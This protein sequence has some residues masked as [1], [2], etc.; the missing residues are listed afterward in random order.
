MTQIP[1]ARR[2]PVA[3]E[4]CNLAKAIDVVGDRWTLLILRAAMYG[5]RRFD[6]FQAELGAPRTVLSG[7]LKTLVAEGLLTK[8]AY[9]S[10]GRRAR[11][12]YV[13][14][15]MGVSLRPILIG[16]TQWGDAW[17]AAGDPPPISFTKAPGK[18]P[19]RAAFVDTEGREVR[20]DQIRPI[21]K[22]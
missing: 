17:L 6:D 12:E 22:G 9:K 18:R 16:L 7:R 14:S 20:P 15:A 2:S 5:V 3:P 11:P 13:L 1:L 21:L 8:Q 19:I 4:T 10:P